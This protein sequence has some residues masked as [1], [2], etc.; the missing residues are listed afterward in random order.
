M[1]TKKKAP[2]RPR[3]KKGAGRQAGRTHAGRQSTVRPADNEVELAEGEEEEEEEEDEG[4]EV[5]QFVLLAGKYEG[6]DGV[7]YEY[8]RDEET[9]IE[10]EKPLD[11][12]FQNKF[13]RVGG[14]THRG[15][16]FEAAPTPHDF[17]KQMDPPF[18][19][20]HPHG[21]QSQFSKDTTSEARQQLATQRQEAVGVE[22]QS[23]DVTSEYEGAS[24]GGLK[25]VKTA[26]GEY[27]VY[28]E[29]DDAEPLNGEPLKGK[30]VK[31]FLKTQIR[32]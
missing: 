21:R 29:E 9:V 25:V 23:E 22:E 15:R 4:Q 26:R 1:A 18:A 8:S 19:V 16:D 14:V 12:M 30:D 11:E 10:S 5:S 17:K 20:T 32:S 31:K 6:E 24:E 28:D 7:M 3:G 13:R 27:Q 2:A